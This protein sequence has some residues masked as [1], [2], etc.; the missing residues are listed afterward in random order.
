MDGVLRSW[1]VPK[2][3]SYDTNDKRLAVKV[4]DHPLEY[5]DFEGVI[6]EGNYGAG[7]VIVWDRGEWIP[8]EDWR[9]GLEKG[10]LLFELRGYKLHGKWTLVKI[11]KSEKDWLLIKERDAYVKS[12]GD[13]VRRDVGAVGAHR[14]RG[15]GG[16][17]PVGRSA[18]G[19]RAGRECAAQPRRSARPSSVML[20][21]SPRQAFTRDGWV[22]ELKLDGYRLLASKR[23][24]RRMLAHAQRQRLHGGLSRGRARGQGAAVRRDHRRRRSRRARPAGQAEL[25][26]AAAA[27]PLAARRSTSSA[28]GRAAG[29]VLRVRPARLRGLRSASAAARSRA[30]AAHEGAA[31]ARRAFTR[32]TTSSAR[33]RRFSRR[34]PRWGSRASSPRRPTRRTAAGRTRCGSRSRP[35]RTGD[36]VIVGFTSPREAGASA[37][38]SWRTC[39]DGD[40]RLRRAASAP[41]STTRCSTSS[42]DARADR[43]ARRRRAARRSARTARRRRFRRRRRRRG[44]IRSMC[45]RCAFASGRRTACCG[46][47]AF[48]RMRTTRIRATA[49]ARARTP[50][51][52]ERRR[53]QPSRPSEDAAAPAASRAADRE[54]VDVLESEE[55]LLAGGGIHQ[56]RSGRLLP[57]DLA[58]DARRI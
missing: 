47:P 5:G 8:L 34:S 19:D 49:S 26:A 42:G 51:A 7:G 16:R 22:F 53:A 11:K 10:K 40:A 33:A 24:A 27:R 44:S 29:D 36:F 41:G 15:E 30:S 20:A 37:R 48:L 3:P 6:P 9:E 18:R 14:R 46:T 58:V 57:R 35:R 2:G 32:S 54:D 39:V 25:L 31:E 55:G 4:E 50:A 56:G 12:P 17:S 52:G 28:R 45:A 43:S 13:A 1:A 21:E 38:C 23:A